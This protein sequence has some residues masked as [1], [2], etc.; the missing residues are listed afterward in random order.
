MATSMAQLHMQVMKSVAVICQAQLPVPQE[1]T[2][3]LAR[4]QEVCVT[5][6]KHCLQGREKS[7]FCDVAYC[8]F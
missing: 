7:I 5:T 3:M 6:V 4:P 2:A 1:P 8:T